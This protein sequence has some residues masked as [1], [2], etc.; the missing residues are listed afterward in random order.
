ME[1]HGYATAGRGL[2][3]NGPVLQLRLRRGTRRPCVAALAAVCL[4]LLG[5]GAATA[6]AEGICG[7]TPLVRDRILA[8]LSNVSDCKLVT[9]ANLAWIDRLDMVG[10]ASGSDPVDLQSG[11]FAGLTRL[12]YLFAGSAPH[13]DTAGRHLLGHREHR[14]HR[15]EQQHAGEP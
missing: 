5:W 4:A 8:A 7:R 11:D 15:P 12:A 14:I 3:R 9:S 13:S 6:Q 1:N 10:G 2:I